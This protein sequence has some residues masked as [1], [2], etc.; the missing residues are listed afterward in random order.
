M[1]RAKILLA[2]VADLPP[3]CVCCGQPATRVRRQEFRLDAGL[4]AS[5]LAA[6][7]LAG[8]LAWTERG[9]T[10]VLPVCKYHRRR[11]RRSTRTLV[12][13][14]ALTAGLGA[15]AY[16]AALFGGPA[17]S[18]LSV[19]AMFAFVVTLVAGMHEVDDGLK[20]Q[21][22]TA[23]SVTLAGAHR[24][25]AEAVGRSAG[26]GTPDVAPDPRRVSDGVRRSPR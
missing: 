20:V 18:Y 12:H 7:V 1:A 16:L 8:G 13:G 14:M 22:L 24:T 19:A 23:D 5:V 17:S 21:S 9:V 15:A 4:S 26:A 10:L 2:R 3:V 6:S 25:F 11:G